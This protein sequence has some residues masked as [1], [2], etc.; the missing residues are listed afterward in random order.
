MNHSELTELWKKQQ[1]RYQE[2]EVQLMRTAEKLRCKIEEILQPPQEGWKELD[3]PIRHRYIDLV[4][5]T[6]DD[7]PRGKV[8]SRE[9]FT[10]EGELVF[11]LRITLDHGVQTYPKNLFHVPVVIRFVENNPEYSFFD[12][13]NWQPDQPER[14][15]K[16]LDS[17]CQTIISHVAEYFGYNPFDGPKK[18]SSIGFIP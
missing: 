18:K 3:K 1:E 16:N 5:I 6:K 2:W 17:F 13:E 4:D 10:S 8:L 14:W 9:S 15:E 12:T 11:G 7:K